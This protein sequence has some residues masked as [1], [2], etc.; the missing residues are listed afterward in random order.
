MDNTKIIEEFRA[1]HGNVAMFGGMKL[2]LV[3]ATGAKTGK[4]TTFP[5]AYT[6]DGDTYVIVASKGG[7]PTHPAWYYNLIAHPQVTVEVGDESFKAHATNITGGERERLFAQHASH[8]PVF[9]TYKEKTSREIP[10]FTLKRI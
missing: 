2:V 5:V 7:A 3:T 8:Y 10:V 9:N 6:K 4:Q 1:N